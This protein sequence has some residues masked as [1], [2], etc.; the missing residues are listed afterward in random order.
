ME[1]PGKLIIPWSL[2]ESKQAHVFT[3]EMMDH[4]RGFL[5]LWREFVRGETGVPIGLIKSKSIG[6]SKVR[7]PVFGRIG[8]LAGKWKSGATADEPLVPAVE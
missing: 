3:I 5:Y 6:L 4:V 8:G 2:V 1:R 7:C